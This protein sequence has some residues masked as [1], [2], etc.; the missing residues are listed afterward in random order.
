MTTNGTKAATPTN[1]LG[2]HGYGRSPLSAGGRS[3]P[4]RYEAATRYA[5]IVWPPKS[6]WK[7]SF[8]L[9]G[10]AGVCMWE[11]VCCGQDESGMSAPPL[12]IAACFFWPLL[13]KCSLGQKLFTAG[14]APLLAMG[15][16]LLAQNLSQKRRVEL[17]GM[18][19]ISH[20][21]PAP[22]PRLMAREATPVRE[23]TVQ[24]A[25]REKPTISTIR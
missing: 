12:T 4:A 11:G 8:V 14:G 17:R 24:A 6:L 25:R 13:S 1:G 7:C 20:G 21:H 23:G 2:C 5:N 10:C 15:L 18:V 22:T 16:C 19:A 3:Q 9:C